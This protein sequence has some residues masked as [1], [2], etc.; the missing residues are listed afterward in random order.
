MAK[1]VQDDTVATLKKKKD[2]R[3]LY[4][5]FFLA[6][7]Y[8]SLAFANAWKK[9]LNIIE[10]IASFSFV[11]NPLKWNYSVIFGCNRN[12]FLYA[13]LI[14]SLLSFFAAFYIATQ[15]ELMTGKEFGTAEWGD[16]AELNKIF[17][18]KNEMENRIYSQNLRISTNDRA[19]KI[20]NNAI[21]VSGS[22]GGKTFRC[23][24]PNIY[25]LCS[26]KTGSAIF[27]D[28]DGGLLK[29]TGKL[30]KQSGKLVKVI[31]LMPGHME[32]SDGIDVMKF[33]RKRTDIIKLVNAIWDNT[34]DPE[35]QSK[36]G[37]TAFFDNSAK[38]LLESLM[39]LVWMEHERFGWKCKF[40]T[41]L[42]LVDMLEIPEKDKTSVLTGIFNQVAACTCNK[43][44]GGEKHP[45][46]KKYKKIMNGAT[47]T[48]QSIIQTLTTRLG[49]FDDEE[50]RRILSEDDIDIT[51][52]CTTTPTVLFLEIPEE[53]TTFNAVAG[54]VY[55]MLF[56]EMYYQARLTIS[57]RL[58]IPVTFWLDEFANIILPKDFPKILS[59]MR[60]RGMSVIIFIQSLSQLKSLYKNDKWEEIID[61]CD[62]F[63]YGGGNAYSTFE[64]ISKMLGQKTIWKRNS[65]VTRGSHSS[66]SNTDD[67]AERK[68]MLPDEVRRLDNEH[69]IILVR[70][71][72]PILDAK[73]DSTK[74]P[75]YARA[76]KLGVYMHNVEKEKETFKI[77]IIKNENPDILLSPDEELKSIHPAL[78]ALQEL[79]I[80][81]K[82]LDEKEKKINIAEMSL[83]ELLSRKDFTLTPEELAEVT[84]GIEDGLSDEEI[85][86]Y[87][88]YGDAYRMKQ[89]RMVLKAIRLRSQQ[90][91]G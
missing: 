9:E 53:D 86:S 42:D 57:G 30:L 90:A 83:L 25:N 15:K 21:F 67:V 23:V 3:L 32:E 56:Q 19:T 22:G 85:K 63:V 71:Q 49:V 31:N 16:I 65:G 37:N 1:K 14:F 48:V 91:G 33:I 64:Q 36:D 26:S 59:T 46:Y 69:V 73:Y 82:E 29:T 11:G 84:A 28:P 61:N 17:A 34:K 52:I 75:F 27:T 58:P 10:Q 45:A 47:E 60:K 77:E 78:A 18:S 38:E 62:T 74:H 7:I 68:L 39:L 4:V 44:N 55:T 13:F 50:I 43:K 81:N 20:N 51:A 35:E 89:Q 40:S 41:V 54:M 66:S 24:T 80:K 76:E 8:F 6:D 72:S 87:I 70:G 5:L 79:V 2:N 88:L 12:V